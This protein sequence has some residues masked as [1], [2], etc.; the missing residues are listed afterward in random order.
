MLRHVCAHVTAGAGEVSVA[1]EELQLAAAEELLAAGEL[2]PSQLDVQMIR[3][4]MVPPPG[5]LG[6][7]DTTE[8]ERLLKD[9]LSVDVG[10]LPRPMFDR[11]TGKMTAAAL[12]SLQQAKA[13][14]A[15]ADDFATA[16]YLR[17][18]I[19]ALGPQEKQPTADD[20]VVSAD[21]PAAAAEVFFRAGFVIVRNAFQPESLAAMMGAWEAEEAVTRPRWEASRRASRGIA[22]HG[23]PPEHVPEGV[24]RGYSQN[25]PGS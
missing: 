3:Q 21:D 7:S 25:Q 14:A 24:S 16:Q 15:A 8:N 22:R 6:Y 19:C 5:Y 10:M 4:L 2:E 12:Q 13:A 11:S 18:T 20:F 17:D 9:S 23:F 1:T